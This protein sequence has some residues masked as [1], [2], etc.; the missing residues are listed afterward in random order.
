MRLCGSTP[1]QL[2][3]SAEFLRL[4]HPLTHVAPDKKSRVQ[5]AGLGVLRKCTPCTLPAVVRGCCVQQANLLKS[6][7]SRPACCQWM[8]GTAGMQQQCE[9]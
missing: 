6:L 8:G 4:A 1:A 2:E 9:A 5:Q 7:S 3:A